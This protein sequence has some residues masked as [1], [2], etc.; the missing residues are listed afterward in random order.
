M[1]GG[2][3]TSGLNTTRLAAV[4]PVMP[5]H[6]VRL[7]TMRRIDAL[8]TFFQAFGLLDVMARSESVVRNSMATSTTNM[9]R[10]VRW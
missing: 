7:N 1:D 10:D 2:V 5:S 4:L 6:E 8:A 3:T 9:M